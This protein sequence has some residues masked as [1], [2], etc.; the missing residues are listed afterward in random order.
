MLK[1]QQDQ[2]WKKGDRFLRI[3]HL[4]RLAVEYKEMTNLETKEGELHVLTKKEFCRLL[5]GAVLL[6]PKS[7]EA[8]E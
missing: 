3:T 7:Q 8:S 2:L 4:E 5:K 1:L 6:P